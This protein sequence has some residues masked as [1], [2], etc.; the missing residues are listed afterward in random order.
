MRATQARTVGCLHDLRRHH[1]LDTLFRQHRIRRD[2]E[3]DLAR[4]EVIGFAVHT[5]AADVAEQARQQGFVDLLV[6]SGLVIETHAHLRHLR[7]QLLVQLVPFAQAQ[8][9]QEFFTALVCPQL[10]GL[11][12]L[13][14]ILEPCP[15]L[16]VGKKI[17]ALVIETLMRGI[18]RLAPFRWTVARILQSQ[19]TGN[20]ENF[21]QAVVL[22]SCQQQARN[23]GIE[24]QLGQLVPERRELTL[25]VNGVQFLQQLVTVRD[26]ARARRLNERKFL[27]LSQA[28]RTH[29]QDDRRQRHAE[30]FGIGKFRS[31]QKVRFFVQ[32]DAHAAHHTTATPGALVRSGARDVLDAQLFHLL[33]HAVAVDTRQPAVDHIA[34]VGHSERSLCHIGC[35]HHAPHAGC[36]FEHA[37]LL[38]DGQAREQRQNFEAFVLVF[39]QCLCGIAYLAFAGKE[40]QRRLSGRRCSAHP[41]HCTIACGVLQCRLLRSAAAGGAHLDRIGA[42]GPAI[43]GAAEMFENAPHPASPK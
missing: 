9:R 20:D 31:L 14:G 17:R 12:V 10:V 19:R 2:E 21:V 1:P 36:G 33:P 8:R 38:G 28:Q 42:A 24:R 4:A 22:P 7:M 35:Q 15:Q 5:L 13:H 37:I 34:D 25:V 43:P 11:L 29:A 6:S 41:A 40:Y 39:A 16:D 18:C 30:N 32:T 3:L 26:G 27:H 23:L